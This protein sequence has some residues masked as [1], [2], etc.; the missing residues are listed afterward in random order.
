MPLGPAQHLN[1]V[2]IEQLEPRHGPGEVLQV[3]D[4]EHRRNKEQPLAANCRRPRWSECREQPEL[5]GRESSRCTVGP[6]PFAQ[7]LRPL[8][9]APACWSC[10]SDKAEML[11]GTLRTRLGSPGSRNNNGL[12]PA[13]RGGL[14]CLCGGL[15]SGLSRLCIGSFSCARRSDRRSSGRVSCGGRRRPVSPCARGHAENTAENDGDR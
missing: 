9:P 15:W 11:I 4:Q 7:R 12:L 2:Y 13:R 3:E 8:A 5:P 6:E 14:S 1:S 10:F